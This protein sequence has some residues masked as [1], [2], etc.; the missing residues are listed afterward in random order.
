M[1]DN[2][3]DEVVSPSN[4]LRVIPDNAKEFQANGHNYYVEDRL[5]IERYKNFQR[6]E[7]E[8]GYGI[9]FS[10]LADKIR[11]AYD[12][13]NERKD[14]DAAV[15]LYTIME[16][17]VEIGEKRSISLYVATLFINRADEDRNVW[18][19]TLA[20]EKLKD[21]SNIDVNFFLIVAL[22]KVRNFS[23]SFKEISQLME[24][25]GSLKS[26]MTESI[27]DE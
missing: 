15:L 24:S 8:L 2:I 23:N 27:F 1:P 17:S 9:R 19:T 14:A 5:S 22:S 16:G 11:Q 25:V 6:M 18:N 12:L 13:L 7:I 20:E 4:P 10:E 3:I 26:K 21:W